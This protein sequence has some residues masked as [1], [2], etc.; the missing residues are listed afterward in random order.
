MDVSLKANFYY[1][2]MV[3]NSTTT[4]TGTTGT[5]NIFVTETVKQFNYELDVKLCADGKDYT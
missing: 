5:S 1:S 4:I 3:D 2:N